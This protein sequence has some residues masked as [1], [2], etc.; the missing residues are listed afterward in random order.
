MKTNK[1]ARALAPGR[2]CRRAATLYLAVGLAVAIV[3]PASAAAQNL[4]APPS[5]RTVLVPQAANLGDYIKDNAAAIRLGKALFWDMQVG[6]DN[7]QSCATCH[8]QA[9]A[10]IRF[11]NVLNPGLIAGDTTFQAMGPGSALFSNLF[12]FT[13]FEST[14]DQTSPMIRSWNDVVSSPGVYNT[15][16]VGQPGNANGPEQGTAVPDPVFNVGGLNT[17]RVEPRNAPTVVNA[18]FNFNNFWD[19]R[20]DSI[21]NGSSPFGDADPNAGVWVN[22]NGTIS[23]VRVR[24][25]FSSLASQAVGPPGSPFEMSF[26]GR[27]FP[28]IGKKLLNPRLVP[29]AN[30]IVH[31]TDSV[32]GLVANSVIRK[33]KVSL[34]RGLATSYASMVRGAFR[35]QLFNSSKLVVL[36]QG[37]YTQ[38]EANFAL[39]FGLAVQAYEAT[40][41]SDDSPY[42]R[43]M[44][45]VAG[46]TPCDPNALSPRAQQGLNIFLTGNDQSGGVGGNCINCHGESTFTNASVMHIRATNFGTDLPE[47]LIERMIMGDGGAS[48]YDAGYYDIAIRPIAEDLGR[49]GNTPF[50][51]ADGTPIPLSFTDRAMYLFNGGAYPFPTAPL[52]CGPND[53]FGRT[54]PFD[55]R[56]ATKGAFKVPTLRNVELTGP[57][58]HNGGEATLMQVVDFYSRGGNFS[59]TNISTFD[60]DIEVLCGLNPH[61]DPAFCNPI[62]PAVAEDNQGKVVDF[63]LSLTDERVRWE[64]APFDH[65]ELFVPDGASLKACG[66]KENACDDWMR[67]P[68]VGAGGRAAES[69]PPLGTFL[70]L[71][72]HQP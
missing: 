60:P 29:L 39:F 20:A 33:G 72:P 15:T 69:L 49:G 44:N 3:A 9:G 26:A 18:V 40:L 19:G 11:R 36:P 4:A 1:A 12:P 48:W 28:E 54:C 71:D 52:P 56:V 65:P 46:I 21:F 31:P 7:V 24:I 32:L 70:G 43:T 67:L 22:A 64:S 55:Q 34:A 50:A 45:C 35:E 66:I 63:L 10:D 62:D 25:P 57:Y 17:R 42:D 37:T 53:P 23:K 6:S 61:P 30:Q 16:Y 59:Q 51:L 5:L 14:D 13:Q 2:L 41:V 38:M 8:F 27:T 47:G 68:P 58:M